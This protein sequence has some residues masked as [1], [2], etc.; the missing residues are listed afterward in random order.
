MSEKEIQNLIRLGVNN[1]AVTF[2]ANVGKLYTE[3]GRVIAT[4]LPKGFPDLFGYCRKDGK[5]IFLEIKTAKGRLRPEQKQ[6]LEQVQKDG[7]RVV[8]TKQEQ[9]YNQRLARY[10]RMS[11]W[12]DSHSIEEQLQL[13]DEIIKVIH[14]CNNALNQVPREV[15]KEEILYGFRE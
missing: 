9:L 5:I 3:D 4:G 1:I 14:D 8:L 10:Q 2:R 7:W 12:C 11:E 6:F 15:N 13:E